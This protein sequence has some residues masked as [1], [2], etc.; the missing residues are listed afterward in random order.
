MGGLLGSTAEEAGRACQSAQA[1]VGFGTLDRLA[2][3]R[4]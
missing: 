2:L 1:E 3:A 4:A